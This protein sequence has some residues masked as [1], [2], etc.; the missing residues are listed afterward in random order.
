M[1]WELQLTIG[2]MVDV[3]SK[4]EI[5]IVLWVDIG[6]CGEVGVGVRVGSG[7]GVVVGG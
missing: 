4:F 2:V 6:V 5:G 3:G 1:K 7:D